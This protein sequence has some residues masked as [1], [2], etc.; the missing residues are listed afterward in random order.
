[1]GGPLIVALSISED[2]IAGKARLA[3]VPGK[4]DSQ[5]CTIFGHGLVDGLHSIEN[6][7]VTARD[8]RL[9]EFIEGVQQDRSLTA[10]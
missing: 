4:N 5:G 2:E 3:R 10:S 8:F 7:C 1:M 6:T 9:T